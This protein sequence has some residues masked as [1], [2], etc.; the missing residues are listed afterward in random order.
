MSALHAAIFAYCALAFAAHGVS[1]QDVAPPPQYQ[2]LIQQ[3]LNEYDLHNLAEARALFNRANELY[4]NARTGRGLG[5]VEFELRNYGESIRH[6]EAALASQVKPLSGSLRA[7]TDELLTRAKAFVAHY[8]LEWSPQTKDSR[9]IVDGV[10]VELAANGA[11]TLT[12]GEH[13]IEVQAPGYHDEKR[14]VRVQ[15]GERARLVIELRQ[16]AR[17]APELPA[18][19]QTAPIH[20]APALATQARP[21]PQDSSLFASPWFWTGVGAVVIA[22]AATAGVLVLREPRVSEI[23][24]GNAGAVTF[25][26]TRLR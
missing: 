11:L 18:P 8:E 25:E 19:A 17:L 23:P 15:G 16:Q 3:A 26:L 13:V 21:A 20:T 24:P 6:L 10:P 5:M 9:I 1:A 7:A 12:V 4:P 22:G 2:A 14:A